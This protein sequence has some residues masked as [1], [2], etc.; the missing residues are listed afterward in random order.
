MLKTKKT[1]FL[2]VLAVVFTMLLPYASPVMAATIP[3]KEDV[4]LKQSDL[5]GQSIKITSSAMF[6]SSNE[7]T[8]PK[9]YSYASPDLNQVGSLA[10]MYQV[11]VASDN[12]PV[13]YDNVLYCID[14]SKT[15]PESSTSESYAN[16]GNFFELSAST[17]GKSKQNGGYD[18]SGM[19]SND[20]NAN[21][22]VYNELCW[23]LQ[24]MYVE[25]EENSLDAFLSK[26]YAD[27]IATKPTM[28]VTNN[29]VET[30][31]QFIEFV[32]KYLK[33]ED[34]H[35]LQQAA[36]WYF[37]NPTGTNSITG[38]TTDSNI[39]SQYPNSGYKPAAANQG[40]NSTNVKTA[41]TIPSSMR[42]S[43][44]LPI[45]STNSGRNFD[46]TEQ[47]LYSMLYSYLI[48]NAKKATGTTPTVTNPKFDANTTPAFSV[49]TI[50]NDS[51][52]K[53]GPFKIDNINNANVD[54]QITD[55]TNT[56]QAITTY[57]VLE[58]TADQN[59]YNLISE[60]SITYSGVAG[61]TFY[62]YV[63]AS[64]D[65]TGI[66]IKMIYH[67]AN[68]NVTFWYKEGKQP[69][70]LVTRTPEEGPRKGVP[71]KKYDLALRKYIKAIDGEELTGDK[72][73][74]PVVD[75]TG[76]IGNANNTAIYKHPKNAVEISKDSKITYELVVY[77]EGDVDAVV[78]EIRDFIPED[79][80]LTEESIAAGWTVENGIAKLT[81]TD[82]NLQAKQD[83]SIRAGKDSLSGGLSVVKKEITLKIKDSAK[84]SITSEKILT[85][86][87]EISDTN[88]NSIDSNGNVVDNIDIDSTP[89][90]FNKNDITDTY[91]GSGEIAPGYIG[92][93]EDDDDF[94]KVKVIVDTPTID[95]ALQKFITAVN[96]KKLTG[97]ESREPKVNTQRLKDYIAGT[98]S[99]SDAT[100]TTKKNA[101]KVKK[102]DIV[103]Y[104]IRVYNEGSKDAYAEKITDYIPEGLGYLVSYEP[105]TI[106]SIE[107]LTE[108]TT[109]P[110]SKIDNAVE[111]LK[112][113][114]A[115]ID[116]NH[117][118]V[119]KGA[120]TL[121]TEKLSCE[122][123][124]ANT[125]NVLK[126]FDGGDSLSYK[127]VEVTCVVLADEV[128]NNNLKNIAEITGHA[129]VNDDGTVSTLPN[130]PGNDRDS[131]PNN[132]NSKNED[133]DDYENLTMEEDKVYDLAL[134]KFITA[135]DGKAITDREPTVTVDANGKVKY[136][137]STQALPVANGQLVEYTIRV[138]NEGNV[139]TVAA[140]IA[141]DLPKGLE[142][143][144]DN[145]TNQ[146]N[147]WK[148]YDK[149]GNE[150]TNTS[151]AKTV[152]SSKLDGA[153]N[154]IEGFDPTKDAKPKSKD[155]KIVFRVNE[156]VIEKTKDTEARTI[157][158]TAEITKETDKEGTDVTD[159]DS[160]PNNWTD[161][162][163]D[164][165]KER[166]YV[167]FFDL[168]LEKKLVKVIVTENG[169]VTEYD[170]NDDTLFKVELNK[171]KL[172]STVVKFV[173]EIT[174]YNKGEIDGYAKEIKDYIPEGLEFVADDNTGWYSVG[175]NVVAT[176][177]LAQTLL[178]A[179]GGSASTNITLKWINS[180]ENMGKKINVAEISKDENDFDTPDIDSVPDNQVPDED[181]IDDA[182]VLLGIS[183]GAEQS[184][185]G[186]IV[187]VAAIMT[188]GIVLIKKY[189][190]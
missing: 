109:L 38:V 169:R 82:G 104:T 45:S 121:N 16:I 41:Y 28:Y 72:S 43:S 22:R 115:N 137:H 129:I 95:L 134:Q 152:R 1:K 123:E 165:D 157:I 180:T 62:V 155:L 116:P 171:K 61:K 85:N 136:N 184:Y 105:N 144:S 94:D 160:T 124:K 2:L 146:E 51:F 127:D 108:G 147:G 71:I 106:W 10:T 20:A 93:I 14:A 112:K 50:E 87:A 118:T 55:Y 66:N 17:L 156:S 132:V 83:G 19:G 114:D 162:E 190:L 163:D 5:D 182:P 76:L 164:I 18:V 46:E 92:G 3:V 142:F 27:Q 30:E 135:V 44:S 158:N 159:Q 52:Y 154:A 54:L 99:V 100:Y 153:E 89:N 39:E 70:V 101:I 65:I 4:V 140:E 47:L 98:S 125:P 13:N 40:F 48:V 36:I 8:T 35:M 91:N 139:D 23:I 113:I 74:A 69:V 111:N 32:K 68:T 25:S 56:N 78:E 149:D 90:N 186:L 166:I 21:Q 12:G 37:T 181:D 9:Y 117:I 73:R 177:A 60:N 167:K 175:A 84:A 11:V 53:F 77:N 57:K 172:N 80:E 75:A 42:T 29:N 26:V 189:V 122:K 7:S 128:K 59:A 107:Q 49:E 178:E 130:E 151:L 179:N 86:V 120:L 33:Q 110:L 96:G 58:P 64:E 143:V 168:E 97:D 174:V 183:T 170:L 88:G 34:I 103:T 119:V 79:M 173:Y 145:K 63:P 133:D 102:G 188:T 138:Y 24:N 131:T 141:D 150:T 185:T 31:V 126:A 148:L 187:A 15:L 176:D 81:I 161:G 6:K 67:D